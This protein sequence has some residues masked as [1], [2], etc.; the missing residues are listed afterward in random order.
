MGQKSGEM[1]RGNIWLTRASYVALFIGGYLIFY[2]LKSW[3][4]YVHDQCGVNN[5]SFSKTFNGTAL[6]W[7]VYADLYILSLAPTKRIK[8]HI[9]TLPSFEAAKEFSEQ[10]ADIKQVT[11]YYDIR[12]P[13]ET[14]STRDPKLILEIICWSFGA[15]MIICSLA[16]LSLVYIDSTRSQ[17]SKSYKKVSQEEYEGNYYASDDSQ[18]Y[19]PRRS[20]ID[21]KADS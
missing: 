9:A 2:G 4:N 20:T 7:R 15:A 5:V 18:S 6:I 8:S 19:I 11:C 12:D 16:V 17:K 1:F 13:F 14:V 21:T 10:F 3:K